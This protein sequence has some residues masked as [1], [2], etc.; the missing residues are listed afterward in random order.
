M[1]ENIIQQHA[2]LLKDKIRMEAYDKAIKE[3]VKPGSIVLDIGCGLGIL[4]FLA[5]KAG[6]RHVHAVEIEPNTLAI[7]KLIAKH[8]GL[9]KKITFHKGLSLK[10]KLKEKADVVIS[11]IFGNLCL[12]ENL[13]PVMIDAKTRFL[14]KDGVIIPKGVKMWFAPCEHKDW[15]FTA[16]YLHNLEGLDM[17]PDL[18]EIDFGVPSVIVKNTEFLADSKVFAEINIQNLR[19]G[20]ISNKLIFEV[21]RDG[22][23]TGFAGWFEA[24]LT[25]NISFTTTP[26]GLTTHWKQGLLPFRTPQTVKTGQKIKLELEIA[27]NAQGLE[28]I[29]SYR[30]EIT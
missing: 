5:L 21:A 20:I 26:S 24:R 10:L 2:V 6:A 19:S 28:S 4:S 1:P 13:L 27:P 9:D 12:N 22:I 8:N 29:I 17:L 14:Q 23:L 30:Y 25:D 18:P 15:E 16:N 7:A 11:E 3:A